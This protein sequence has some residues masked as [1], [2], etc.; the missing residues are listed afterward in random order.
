MITLAQGQLETLAVFGVGNYEL[1]LWLRFRHAF[2]VDAC[3]TQHGQACQLSENVRPPE[4]QMPA[5]T[6][7]VTFHR[8]LDW[9][10]VDVI[11]GSKTLPKILPLLSH[12]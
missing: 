12:L 7:A 1:A 4:G 6:L 3:K 5:H 2:E 8:F 9:G 11:D 10:S